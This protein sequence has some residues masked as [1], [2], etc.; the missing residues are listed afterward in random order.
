MAGRKK[1]TG[2]DF[3]AWDVDVFADRKIERLIDAKG[4]EGFVVFFCVCQRIYAT[5]GYYMYW[6][7]E[8]APTIKKTVGGDI[9]TKF[10]METVELC[11][12]LGLFSMEMYALY[13]V[14]TSKTI[15]RNFA[16]VLPRR[17]RKE[18]VAEYWLLGAE[19]G[20]GAVPVPQAM[21]G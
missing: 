19:D 18:V 17:R 12:D 9:D 5:N 11:L 4:P 3:S 8:D 15:Q 10:I 14:L 20:S 7:A 16:V 21:M 6:T 1:K 13:G 2:I